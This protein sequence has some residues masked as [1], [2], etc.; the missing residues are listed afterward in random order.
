M[1]A[2]IASDPVTATEDEHEFAVVR[3]LTRETRAA[4]LFPMGLCVL[5]P[6]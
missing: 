5:Q 2:N 3:P 1:S 6:A 4:T